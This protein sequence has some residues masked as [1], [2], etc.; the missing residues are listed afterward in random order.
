M[1]VKLILKLVVSGLLFWVRKGSHCNKGVMRHSNTACENMV[2]VLLLFDWNSLTPFPLQCMNFFWP[3]PYWTC[4][5]CCLFSLWPQKFTFSSWESH[6]R[7]LHWKEHFLISRKSVIL[8]PSC[9]SYL[10]CMHDVILVFQLS[11][12]I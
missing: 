4:Q 9:H 1:R 5:M 3:R 2:H 7:R 10:P 6:P 8:Y 11:L 12:L